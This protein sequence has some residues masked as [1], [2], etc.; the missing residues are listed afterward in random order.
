VHF[1]VLENQYKLLSKPSIEFFKLIK[2]YYEYNKMG[3]YD[4]KRFFNLTDRVKDI[5][6][7]LIFSR[8][9]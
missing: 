5:V 8:N 9:N 2:Q 3:I 4:K 6:E 7:K 1:L